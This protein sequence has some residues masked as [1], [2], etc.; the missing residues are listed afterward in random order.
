M[1][2]YGQRFEEM[3]ATP[4]GPRIIGKK[5]PTLYL[6]HRWIEKG[7]QKGPILFKIQL[8]AIKLLVFDTKPCLFK[9]MTFLTLRM[10]S[11]GLRFEE[12]VATPPGPRINGKNGPTLNLKH[13]WIEM[14]SQNGKILSKIQLKAIKSSVF[15]PEPCLFKDMIKLTQKMSSY[16]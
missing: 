13:R 7:S 16:S 8:K 2:S 6:K 10:A 9:D 1:S 3:V 12:M 11:Y 5:D 15:D 4:P 14:G